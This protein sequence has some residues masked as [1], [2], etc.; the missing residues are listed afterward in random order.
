MIFCREKRCG[1][2]SWR[3]SATNPRYDVTGRGVRRLTVGRDFLRLS[4]HVT[5]AAL[6]SVSLGD[7]CG[8]YIFLDEILW[9]KT[10]A[11][12]SE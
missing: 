5:A 11:S 12:G 3:F 4:T 6:F 10:I 9:V 1:G 8:G 7:R 2:P